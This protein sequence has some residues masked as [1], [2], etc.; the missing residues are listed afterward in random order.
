MM[1]DR[2]SKG[3]VSQSQNNTD[4][5]LRYGAVRTSWVRARCR[6]AASLLADDPED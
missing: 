3:A 1:I 6:R 2:Q 5:A 4:I